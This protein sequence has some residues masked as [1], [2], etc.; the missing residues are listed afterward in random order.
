METMLLTCQK[1]KAAKYDDF[2]V[3]QQDK[4]REDKVCITENQEEETRGK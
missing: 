3:G 2:R 1:K 4:M